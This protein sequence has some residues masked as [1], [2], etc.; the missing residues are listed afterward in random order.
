MT[1]AHRLSTVKNADR[2]YAVERGRISEVGEHN[3]LVENDGKYA[4][5]SAIQ[6]SG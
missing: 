5:L 1:I 2:I 6:A 4:E 3:E